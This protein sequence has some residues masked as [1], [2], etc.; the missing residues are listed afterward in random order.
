MDNRQTLEGRSDP[1]VSG[2]TNDLQ[3]DSPARPT[4][5]TEPLSTPAKPRVIAAKAAASTAPSAQ[6]VV[7]KAVGPARALPSQSPATQPAETPSSA[8]VV[9]DDEVREAQLEA[10]EKRKFFITAVPGWL[11]SLIAHIGLILILAAI[12]L[13]PIETVI[14]IL[15][16][17]MGEDQVALDNFELQGP[18]MDPAD[19]FEDSF[20]V[21]E[22]EMTEVAMP[23]VTAPEM[24]NL[25]NTLQDLTVNSLTES[26]IPKSML[27]SSSASAMSAALDSRSSAAAKGEMLERYG[28]NANS[29]KAVAM[30]LK[31]IAAHQAPDGGWSFAHSAI[32]RNQC[33][34]SGDLAFARNGATAMALLP[35]LGAGQTHLE[36]EYKQ[37]IK[38]GLAFLIK[39]MKVT[40][41]SAPR[42][43]WHEPG[44]RTYSHGLAAIAIC[45]AYAMTRDYDLAQPAQLALNY[46]IWSQDSRGGGWRYEPHQP[47]DTSV[48]GWCLMALKSGKMGNLEIPEITF[49]G[50]DR[51]LGFV[52]TNYGAYYGY[53]EP[54]A[55][56]RATTTA[57]GLLCRMYLGYPKYDPGLQEGIEFLSKRGPSMGDLYY[58]YY[59][60]QVMRHHG[61]KEWEKWNGQLRDK[62]IARQEKQGHAAGSWTVGN[63][64][65]AKGGRLYATSLATMILEVYYRH[66]PL[67][68][69]QSLEDFEI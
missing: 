41:G 51:F 1:T 28:G 18:A 6:V 26:V 5:T 20:S 19:T 45:E 69:Q 11:I 16:A 44:G 9:I 49:K 36:G 4:S 67:Y 42:G 40:S 48:V 46:L 8:T 56:K 2:Q 3:R 33:R 60:T 61:G 47:G 14:N 68:S 50:A 32:C 24:V 17:S 13:N 65:A 54:S 37:Q 55:K 39:R 15:D 23:E 53:D 52:S 7:A 66:L 38:R 63:R 59:A 29:E 22:S 12:S 25:D 35:F 21:P 10:A 27:S 64:H 34:D 31:W 43:S 62:L 58:T 30:A 57:V